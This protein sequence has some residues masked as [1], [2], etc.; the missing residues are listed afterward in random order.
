MNLNV[1]NFIEQHQN[2][3]EFLKLEL[4]ERTNEFNYY[5]DRNN[6]LIQRCNDKIDRLNKLNK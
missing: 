6:R 4:E 2:L 1:D 5:K 3:I